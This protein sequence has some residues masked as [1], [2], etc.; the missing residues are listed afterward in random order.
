M[1]KKPNIF[2]YAT[3][4]LSQDA[5]IAWLLAWSD[6]NYKDE[7]SELHKLGKELLKAMCGGEEWKLGKPIKDSNIELEWTY[8]ANDKKRKERIDI[9]AS[10]ENKVGEKAYL[11]VEDKV[12]AGLNIEQLQNYKNT[13]ANELGKG[14]K[15]KCVHIKTGNF[16]L[17]RQLCEQL[18]DRDYVLIYRELMLKI[19]N[20][21]NGDNQIVI[22]FKTRW[23]EFEDETNSFIN[24]N[25]STW[26]WRAW[27]GFGNYLHKEFHIYDS[28]WNYTNNPEDG[29]YIFCAWHWQSIP[30]F[31]NE[32]VVMYIQ[33]NSHKE[34]KLE[35]RLGFKNLWNKESKANINIDISKP[36]RLEYRRKCEEF[37]KNRLNY[38]P[39]ANRVR[40]KSF[41]IG[42][43]TYCDCNYEKLIVFLEDVSKKIKI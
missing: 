11:I 38:T 14:A 6:E 8:K 34:R 3:N 20:K 43:I 39:T 24:G 26:S 1:N 23:Q 21:Y 40:G 28:H 5:F 10:L 30:S 33:I 27:E 41:C 19:L 35:I 13:I 37:L 42:H 31:K 17:T 25:L 15:I 9:L 29:N 16:P 12:F 7:Y 2:K 36:E 22:D 18:K 32:D 4:E